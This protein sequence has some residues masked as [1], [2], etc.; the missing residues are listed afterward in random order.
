MRISISIIPFLLLS[1][2]FSAS[3]DLSSD[4]IEAIKNL[5][6]QDKNYAP[7]FKLKDS[8]DTLH[9]LSKLRGNVVLI[10][11]WA[12]W[13]GPCRQEIPDFIELYDKYHDQGFEILGIS[14]SDSKEALANFSNI[15]KVSYP[16]L[17]GNNK[18]I[19]DITNSYGGIPAV[20]WS[21]LVGIDGEIIAT[22]PGAILKQYD[23]L[24]YYRLE[25]SIV[26][27]IKKMDQPSK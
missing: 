21:F 26:S 4:R 20:P 16:L 8:V 14:L 12:T 10:N 13:C 2:L 18:E 5:I 3:A 24:T 11:F 7:D 25:Q 6:K 15:Y 17:Y 1:V 22:Y 9:V 27:E 19:S 23:P